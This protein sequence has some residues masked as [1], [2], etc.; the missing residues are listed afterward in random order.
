MLWTHT[1]LY[2]SNKGDSAERL[3]RH[4]KECNLETLLEQV[5]WVKDEGSP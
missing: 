3:S 4:E 5:L 1:I 2:L